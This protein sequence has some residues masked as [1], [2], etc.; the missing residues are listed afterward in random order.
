MTSEE[1]DKLKKEAAIAAYMRSVQ[2]KESRGDRYAQAETSS[3]KGLYQFTDATWKDMEKKVGRKLNVYNAKDQEIAMRKFT[4]INV[5]I[6]E[7]NGI[8]VTPQNLYMTHFLGSHGG[9]KFLKALQ[10]NPNELASKYVDKATFNANK[11]LFTKDGKEVTAAELYNKATSNIQGNTQPSGANY[12]QS[13]QF[14]QEGQP[15]E[16]AREVEDTT[17]VQPQQPQRTVTPNYEA[18]IKQLNP[19]EK[20]RASL[21]LSGNFDY[22]SSDANL[23]FNEDNA[24]GTSSEQDEELGTED[25]LNQAEYGG[26]QIDP[27]KKDSK[28]KKTSE[29]IIDA[30]KTNVILNQIPLADTAYDINNTFSAFKEGDAFG[31]SQ[32]MLGSLIPGLSGKVIEA[33][34][35]EIVPKTPQQEKKKFKKVIETSPSK[36]MEYLKKYGPGYLNNPQFKKDNNFEYGGQTRTMSKSIGNNSN[37]LNEFNTGGLHEENKHG[38]IPQGIGENGKMNTVEEGETK[39]NDYIFSNSLKINSD[40]VK[41]LFLDEELIDMTFADASK[42]INKILEDNPND[43]IIK[44]TVQKQLDSL[45]L[46]N[47]KARTA[48]EELDINL[49]LTEPEDNKMMFGGMGGGMGGGFMSM[50]GG[51]G[52][53]GGSN[54]IFVTDPKLKEIPEEQDRM[55]QPNQMFLGGFGNNFGG[56]P[57]NTD[58]YFSTKPELDEQGNQIMSNA[59][60][61]SANTESS[62]KANQNNNQEE[63]QNNNNDN[64]NQPNKYLS[65]IGAG[66]SGLQKGAGYSQYLENRYKYNPDARAT[67]QGMESIKDGVEKMPIIGGFAKTFR[68]IENVGKQAGVA[69]GG[70][71]GGNAMAGVMDPA[72]SQMEIMKNKDSKGWQKWA[73]LINPAMSG[74]IAGQVRE[75]GKAR[76]L[77]KQ[78]VAQN[79]QFQDTNFAKYGGEMKNKNIYTNGGLKNIWPGSEEYWN[80]EKYSSSKE[81]D[82]PGFYVDAPDNTVIYPQNEY[83]ALASNETEAEKEKKA[84]KVRGM[85]PLQY[86]S[87][88]GSGLNYLEDSKKKP[89]VERLQR[90]GDKFIARYVDESSLQKILDQ[91]L[92]NNINAIS[93]TG[94]SQ[95]AVR[96]AIG[97]AS[98]AKAKARNEAYMNMEAKNIATDE[99]GQIFDLDVNK[100]NIVQD[101][102]E[103][104]INAKNRARVEDQKRL[105]RNQLFANIAAI[106][107]EGTYNN[108]L[109]NLTGYGAQG[110][111]MSDE[112]RKTL[113]QYLLGEKDSKNTNVT[114]SG[115]FL[116][117]MNEALN[118]YDENKKMQKL[119]RNI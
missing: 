18:V 29:K 26:Y 77:N 91:E 88:F 83:P 82:R 30:V 27:K 112:D 34:M 41:N 1:E 9:P 54:N 2:R 101:N 60:Q 109:K 22:L 62:F 33:S 93:Q 21:D 85:N 87:V 49:G 36:R 111:F 96:N 106:G 107:K 32:N 72:T 20:Q 40:D 7:K 86:A 63:N 70:E 55:F 47:E 66:T 43:K 116:D 117:S 10:D 68:A 37:L 58:N 90:L 50:L 105:S 99:R 8:P 56:G 25:Y 94:A 118:E 97:S 13:T 15:Q 48:K 69:I 80:G 67:D 19:V 31:I 12:Q 14:N 35:S 115:G 52:G 39:Y 11:N 44:K 59:N 3:A 104:E 75:V 114:K 46:G 45:V 103:K 4:D 57:A 65:A 64:N 110:D 76:F 113:L 95:G 23:L 102:S 71:K 78:S 42:Y 53:G 100:S 6:L 73:S 38:G 51:G 108:R 92:N 16:T 79:R 28:F 24:E 74:V 119:L 98:L 61:F 84:Y 5:G 17:Q 89:E 81:Y